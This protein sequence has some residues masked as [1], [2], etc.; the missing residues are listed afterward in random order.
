MVAAFQF[1]FASSACKYHGIGQRDVFSECH[2]ADVFAHK[3]KSQRKVEFLFSVFETCLSDV[4]CAN[5][6]KQRETCG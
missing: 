6:E 2:Q 4:T 3:T 5:E 1:K